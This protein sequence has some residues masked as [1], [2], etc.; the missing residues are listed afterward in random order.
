VKRKIIFAI[1]VMSGLASMAAQAQAQD[2]GRVISVTG[3]SQVNVA[4]DMAVISLGVTHEDVD[5]KAAMAATSRDVA[6]ILDKLSA[7]NIDARDMQ[8]SQFSL[9]PVWDQGDNVNGARPKITG[10]VASNTVTVRIRDLAA[11]GQ[12]LNEVIAD[13]ANDFNGLQFT[14]QDLG[15]LE[16]QARMGATANAMERA[17]VLAKAAGVRLGPVQS[18]TEMNRGRQPVMME[19]SAKSDGGAPIAAGEVSITGSVQMV[20]AILD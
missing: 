4:P 15:P 16:A 8:T 10:F 13:G 12:I 11:L 17:A 7:L 19:M 20:F 18:I 6:G 9:N 14:V 1:L 5:A 3:E 2:A